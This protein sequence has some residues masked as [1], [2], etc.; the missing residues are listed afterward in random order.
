MHFKFRNPYD[1]VEW[2]EDT[3]GAGDR[4]VALTP[5]LSA[6]NSVTLGPTVGADYASLCFKDLDNDGVK[7]VI[8][9]TSTSFT[10]DEALPERHILKYQRSLNGIGK[11]VLIKNEN[12]LK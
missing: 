12:L 7:E 6:D 11:F 5:V 8:I 10:F 9:E 1:G 4:Y 3:P 2:L